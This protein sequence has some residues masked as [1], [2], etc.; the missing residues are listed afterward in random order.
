MDRQKII[1]R[2][3][4]IG[5]L[6]NL[7]LA[8]FKAAV[9]LLSN[10]ISVVL[11]AVNN[12]SDALSSVITIIGAKL[13]AKPADKKHP[14][15]YGRVEYLSALIIGV[16]VLYAGVT[17]A[18]ESVK[19][20]IEPEIP[21]YS[22]VALIIIAVAVLV[23]IVLGLYVIRSGRR[24]NS[25]ALVASG[26]D[27]LMD[28]IISA[29]V[30]LAAAIYLI[31]GISLEAYLGV[32]ISVFIMKA[33]FEVLRD[34]ISQL[35][36]ERIDSELSKTIKDELCSYPEVSG[37]YDLILH[38]Y[39]PE[40]LT[41][42]V[43]IEVADTMT[44]VELDALE[45]RITAEMYAKHKVAITGIS[46]YAVNLSDPETDNLFHAVHDMVMAYDEVLQIHGFHLDK[47]KSLVNFDLIIGFD[48]KDRLAV[49]DEI[50]ARLKEEY[51]QYTFCIVLDNDISD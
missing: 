37:A 45:R 47:E 6:A 35:L 40:K 32:I 19:K 44:A 51:P 41:G 29:S 33:G 13:S 12:L 30:L 25:D 14:L 3:S 38:A 24:A 7:F 48:A 49:R 10:S 21:D 46:V 20:I 16:I 23:K 27:A 11:D 50:A 9:G 5:I 8:G 2:T 43:H 1:V 34:T 26:K 31:W 36:G 15:G 4:I 22:A 28:S 18:I 39:G 42:S 17:A